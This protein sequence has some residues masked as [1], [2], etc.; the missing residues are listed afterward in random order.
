[1]TKLPRVTATEVLR[2]LGKDGWYEVRQSGSHKVLRNSRKPGSVIVAYHSGDI[3]RLK[4]LQSILDGA[5]LT[6]EEFRRLM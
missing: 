5:N 2:A 4:T 3:L 6:V 1:M